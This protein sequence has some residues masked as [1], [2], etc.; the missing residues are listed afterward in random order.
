MYDSFVSTVQQEL[1][2]FERIL[3]PSSVMEIGYAIHVADDPV[4]VGTKSQRL[5]GNLVDDFDNLIKIQDDKCDGDDIAYFFKARAIAVSLGRGISRR[6]LT[7]REDIER[8][9]KYRALEIA[10]ID[11]ERTQTFWTTMLYRTLISGGIGFAIMETLR[12]FVHFHYEHAGTQVIM[13]GFAPSVLMAL[14]FASGSKVVFSKMEDLR[15]RTIFAHF[16]WKRSQAIHAYESGKLYEFERNYTEI[17]RIWR[18]YTGHEAPESIPFA[19]VIAENIQTLKW[20]EQE[21]RRQMSSALARI[22]DSYRKWRSR[23]DPLTGMD[24]T[25]KRSKKSFNLKL[26]FDH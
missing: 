21:Q 6:K 1:K 10:R 7:Y 5:A 4:S 17:K 24:S 20:Q 12:P 19:A 23:P 18:D 25:V 14:L 8:A 11:K 13:T 22:M 26:G 2:K 3:D 15:Y 9:E 16:E